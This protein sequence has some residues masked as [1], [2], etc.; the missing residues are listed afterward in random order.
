MVIN[1]VKSPPAKSENATIGCDKG[2]L[3][4]IAELE[5][6]LAR[7][8]ALAAHDLPYFLGDLETIRAVAWSRL[9]AAA[10]TTQQ[11]RDELISIEQA[12]GRLGLSPSY[13][14]RNHQQFPFTRR[15]GR[16]L[17]FSSQGLQ[18]YIERTG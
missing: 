6:V 16:S 9:T 18:S 1:P 12:A 17:R 8:R 2:G 15:V 10:T 14:Y 5:I 4:V 11:A 13:L 3:R 7:A